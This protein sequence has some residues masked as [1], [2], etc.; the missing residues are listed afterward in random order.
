[1]RAVG[2]EPLIAALDVIGF[3]QPNAGRL[4]I[5]LGRDNLATYD[6]S[7]AGVI[8]TGSRDQAGVN[9]AAKVN[10]RRTDGRV[11][12]QERGDP[13]AERQYS[14]GVDTARGIT[15]AWPMRRPAPPLAT[16]GRR[17]GKGYDRAHLPPP[18]KESQLAGCSRRVL[19]TCRRLRHARRWGNVTAKSLPEA[20]V[21]PHAV[22]R[23]LMIAS[24][25][26]G[27]GS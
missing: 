12:R 23:A 24:S 14:G 9:G 21:R 18:R 8:T 20:P 13:A 4:L 7:G 3:T 17:L 22:T 11:D 27:R 25:S 1:M 10:D 19:P 6:A 16:D 2:G 5:G 26:K 15:I